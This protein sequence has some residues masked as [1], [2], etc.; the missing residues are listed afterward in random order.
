MLWK[1][2]NG[3]YIDPNEIISIDKDKNILRVIMRSYERQFVF[4]TRTKIG[5]EFIKLIDEYVC[6]NER[7]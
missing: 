1:F 6:D 3:F 7:Y 2:G 4:N 5:K